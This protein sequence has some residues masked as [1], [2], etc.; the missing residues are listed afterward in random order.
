[1]AFTYSDVGL[2]GRFRFGVSVIGIWLLLIRLILLG[3]RLG[4][5]LFGSVMHPLIFLFNLLTFT[6]NIVRE[7]FNYLFLIEKIYSLV[8][9]VKV[10]FQD[11]WIG[12][13]V[14]LLLLLIFISFIHVLIIVEWA[15]VVFWQFICL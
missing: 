7:V 4:D 1:M 9:N 11:V 14:A 12:E 2:F 13:N 3:Y 8:Q 15:W 6:F 10:H 5:L